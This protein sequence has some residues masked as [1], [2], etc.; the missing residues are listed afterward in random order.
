MP[1]PTPTPFPADLALKLAALEQLTNDE[2]QRALESWTPEERRQSI[3]H[4]GG[5]LEFME[6][7]DKPELTEAQVVDVVRRWLAL[8]P[9]SYSTS[10][11][12]LFDEGYVP[13][14]NYISRVWTVEVRKGPFLLA[15]IVTVSDETGQVLDYACSR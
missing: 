12:D 11:Q 9:D 3:D 10:Y 5:P 7:L 6:W 14:P 13:V 2:R 15:A 4:L 1:L 8:R